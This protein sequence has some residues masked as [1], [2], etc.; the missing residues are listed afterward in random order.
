VP[1]QQVQPRLH[2]DRYGGLY[3]HGPRY[4][5]YNQG[6]RFG[7]THNHGLRSGGFNRDGHGYGVN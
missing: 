2:W 4:G 1:E 5:S 3:N 7:D 6:K